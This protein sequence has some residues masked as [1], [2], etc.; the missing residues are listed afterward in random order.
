MLDYLDI[1]STR[2]QDVAFTTRGLT[3]VSGLIG[4]PG[5]RGTLFERPEQDG[6]V[7]P[8]AQFLP[9]RII[10]LE[11][12]T[13]QASIDA[14]FTDFSVIAKALEACLSAGVLMKYR[15]AG[16][17]RDL[18]MTVKLAGDISPPLDADENVPMLGYQVQLRA[19]DPRAYSQTLQSGSTG[20]P[21]ATGGFPLPV[22]FPIPFGSGATGGSVVATNNGNT[23]SWPT[24]TLIGPAVGPVITVGSGSLIFDTLNLGAGQTLVIETNSTIRSMLV[25]GANAAGSL[26][27]S[28]SIFAGLP[29]G[30]ATN[31]SFYAIGGGTTVA[32]TLTV[33]WRDAWTS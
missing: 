15:P 31:V 29:A 16:G 4:L 25:N 1:G 27:Y 32:T 5:V 8:Y 18:Q 3:K 14:A 6:A 12:E 7:E 13:W 10:T 20:A 17:T 22:P 19:A 2:L 24:L 28:D 11:G 23:L 26:R 30:V 9:E 21:S 33:A